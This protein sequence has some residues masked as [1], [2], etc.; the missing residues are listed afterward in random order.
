MLRDLSLSLQQKNSFGIGLDNQW[1]T[2]T[3]KTRIYTCL[4]VTV[5]CLLVLV[6]LVS[7]GDG[8]GSVLQYFRY[9][10]N[11]V[12]GGKLSTHSGELQTLGKVRKT[13]DQKLDKKTSDYL[14]LGNISDTL[15]QNLDN[16]PYADQHRRNDTSEHKLKHLRKSVALR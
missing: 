8:G 12:N 10:N 16:I 9:V 3:K 14:T 11:F 6:Q 15:G 5:L 1:R 13:Q 4:A 2:T 7:R